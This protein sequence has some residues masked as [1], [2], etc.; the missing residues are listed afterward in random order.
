MRYWRL[1]TVLLVLLLCV[2]EVPA[3]ERILNFQSEIQILPDSSLQVHET[4]KVQSE[5]RSIRHGIYRDFPT[6][7]KG[8]MR[9]NYSVGF[10]VVDVRRDGE[11]ESYTQEALSN[12]VRIRIGSASTLVS[13]GE[14]IYELTYRVTR[15]LGFFPGHDELYWNVTGNGWIFPIDHASA[16][17]TLPQPVP[18]D[19]LQLTG[20]TGQQGSKAQDLIMS[21]ISDTEI[22]FAITKPLGSYEGMTIVVQFP[23]GIIA[24]PTTAQKAQNFLAEN[25]TV[26]VAFGGLVIVLIYYLLAWMRVGRDPHRGTIVVRYE[27][28]AGV[29]PAAIAFLRHMGY[30]DRVLVSAVVNLAVQG[31]L[32]IQ[33][34]ASVYRLQR[35]KSEDSRLA[36][37][38]INLMRSLFRTHDTVDVTQGENVTFQIAKATLTADLNRSENQKLFQKH[39]G[40]MWPGILLSLATLVAMVLTLRAQYAVVAAF[41]SFWLSI[42]SF[43]TGAAIGGVIQL[44]RRKSDHHPAANIMGTLVLSIVEVAVLVVYAHIVGY[45]PAVA[46]LLI[47]GVNFVFAYAIRSFTP[48]GR[49]LMDEIDGFEQFLTSV[50]SDRLQRVGAPAKTPALFEKCLPYALALGVEQQWAQQFEGLLAQAAVAGAA[51]SGYSPVWYSSN[52]WSG[53]NASSFASGFGGDFSSA[54]SSASTAPGS[55]SG[56]GGGGSSGGGGGGGGGGGW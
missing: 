43:A 10:D 41:L 16:I 24:E 48:E 54:V 6:T 52:D 38:E 11:T 12:G 20:Y 15:E 45:L 17:V 29:S 14:H 37:E 39:R 9:E 25:A 51:G 33:Q 27:P 55:S 1:P 19:K 44:V 4:I 40:A 30:G 28:P 2:A 18:A 36:P 35:L 23:K 42:W 7:Y 34:E 22:E 31:Y 53:F 46:L 32:A 21:R 50:D 13:R 8:R 49:R 5:G 47:I 3:T 56:G 26:L